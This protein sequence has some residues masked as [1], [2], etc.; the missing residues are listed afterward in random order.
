MLYQVCIFPNGAEDTPP[1]EAAVV[2]TETPEKVSP[3]VEESVVE[4]VRHDRITR[5][6]I[7]SYQLRQISMKRS[8]DK[9]K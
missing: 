6:L 7:N 9:V 4:E 3:V 2:A 8:N 1:D 5:K